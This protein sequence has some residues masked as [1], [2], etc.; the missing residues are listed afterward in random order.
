[1]RMCERCSNEVNRVNRDQM[2]MWGNEYT[3]LTDDTECVSSRVIKSRT[4][5]SLVPNPGNESG[6]EQMFLQMI[7]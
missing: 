4:F 1:M 3:T 7:S 5:L 2:A 6:F